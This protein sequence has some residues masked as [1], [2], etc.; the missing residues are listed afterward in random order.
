MSVTFKIVSAD[1]KYRWN[2]TSSNPDCDICK[3]SLLMIP[4]DTFDDTKYLVIDNKLKQGK[5]LHIFHSKCIDKI[6]I[7]KNDDIY[8]YCP[9]CNKEWIIHNIIN[10][11]NNIK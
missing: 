9:T 10:T 2:I 11:N 5:C 8:T 6:T 4:P 1:I 7:K 3:T